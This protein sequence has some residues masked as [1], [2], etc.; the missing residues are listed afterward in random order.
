MYKFDKIY[1]FLYRKASQSCVRVFK[2][3]GIHKNMR[4]LGKIILGGGRRGQSPTAPPP[5]L[6]SVCEQRCVEVRCVDLSRC[7][8]QQVAKDLLQKTLLPLA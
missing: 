2:I 6:A 7:N 3:P 1:A 8:K 4:D 5:P